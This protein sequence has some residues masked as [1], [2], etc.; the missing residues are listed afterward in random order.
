MANKQVQSNSSRH[1]PVRSYV[2]RAG[3]MTDAQRKAVHELLPRYGIFVSTSPDEKVDALHVF[4]RKAPLM[5]EVGF[6]NGEALI[7]MARSNPEHDF[8]GIEVHEP[9]IG[10]LLLRIRDEGLDNIRVIH[11]DA[12]QILSNLFQDQLFDRICLFFPDPW[13]KKRHHKRR[14]FTPHFA[15]LAVSKLKIGGVLHF[16]T[17]WQD[18]AGQVLALLESEPALENTAE[19]GFSENR[20]GRPMTKFE[21]RGRKLGHGVWDIVMRKR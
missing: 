14:I 16:A 21:Q 8:I 19:S 20:A 10:H 13:P 3:R 5:L 15:G 1:D 12:V 6:G 18:Y 17:D 9:G 2:I 7:E 11:G 4:G